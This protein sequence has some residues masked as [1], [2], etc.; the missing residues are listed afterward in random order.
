MARFKSNTGVL[1]DFYIVLKTRQNT[2]TVLD[3][4]WNEPQGRSAFVIKWQTSEFDV[5]GLFWP[6]TVLQIL[7]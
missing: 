5:Q 4:P 3:A 2:N 1:E 7:N 6:V